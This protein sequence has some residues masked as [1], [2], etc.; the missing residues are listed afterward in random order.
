M[1]TATMLGFAV[2]LGAVACSTDGDAQVSAAIAGRFRQGQGTT[3]TMSELAPFEWSRLYVFPPY[4]TPE[5][6]DRELGFACA[7]WQRADIEHR[8][9]VYLLIFVDG[10]RVTRHVAHNRAKGD[11]AGLHRVGGYTRAEAVFVVDSSKGR[12]R[13]IWRAGGPTK[14]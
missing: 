4:T 10:P 3:L 1:R 11:F 6:I 12:R 9:D 14:G 13:L 7:S 5:Q 2:A 8:D